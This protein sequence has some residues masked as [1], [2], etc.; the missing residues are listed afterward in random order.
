MVDCARPVTRQA[1]ARVWP[2]VHRPR[3]NEGSRSAQSPQPSMQDPQ[4][5]DGLLDECDGGGHFILVELMAAETVDGRTA[6]VGM[7]LQPEWRKVRHCTLEHLR[8]AHLEAA[9]PR[10]D[11]GA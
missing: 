3:I 9:V 1:R 2:A 10:N 8:Q 7:D 6:R 11:D 5:V 4:S